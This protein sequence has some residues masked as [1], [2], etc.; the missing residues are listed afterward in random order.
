M[1]NAFVS[2]MK[3]VNNYTLTENGALAMKSTNSAIVD[4]FGTIGSLRSRSVSEIERLFSFAF[5][6]VS[7]MR[8]LS[9]S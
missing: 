7:S 2:N 6:E 4:L 8:D 9:K 5:A 1:S 3:K